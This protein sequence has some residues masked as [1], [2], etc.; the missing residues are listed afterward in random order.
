MGL[1]LDRRPF[2]IK[3]ILLDPFSLPRQA[4]RSLFISTG[5]LNPSTTD[6]LGQM[7]LYYR[8]LHSISMPVA[9]PMPPSLTTET[10]PQILQHGENKAVPGGLG[11]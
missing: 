1:I 8:L 10:C 11:R 2:L 6:I 4:S 3:R 7:R 5:F 9:Y